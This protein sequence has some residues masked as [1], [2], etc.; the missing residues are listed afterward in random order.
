MPMP[1]RRGLVRDG[2]VYTVAL[3]L[4]RGFVFLLIPVATRILGPEEFGVVTAALVVS[5]VLSSIFTLGFNIA[6]VRL[7]FDEPPDQER[8]EWAMLI[9]AQLLLGFALAGIAWILGPFW[10]QIYQ[11]VP[12]AGPLQAAVIL[13][14][15]QASQATTLGV[16]RAARRVHAFVAV[17]VVQVVVGGVL[18]IV[19]AH[20]S[21]ATGLVAGMA[22]G[23]GLAALLGVV[24][25]YH[26]P[27]W[28]RPAFRAALL[29]AA[30]FVAHQLASWALSLSDRVLVE[31]FM[32]LDS[33]ASYQI[34]YAMAIIPMLLT[35]AVQ[36][37]WL[38]HFYA[39]DAATKRAIPGRL[40]VKATVTVAA[41]S[42]VIVLFA[43]ALF[44]ILAPADFGYPVTVVALVVSATFVR[45]SYVLVFATLSDEKDSRSIALA[46]TLG[47]LANVGLNLLLIPAWG[48]NGAAA[49]TLLAYAI[50]SWVALRRA[51]RVVGSL[52]VV[53]LTLLW[54]VGV[55]V[56]LLLSE[57]P[58]DSL[59]WIAR[60][61]IATAVVVGAI[62]TARRAWRDQFSVIA[63]AAP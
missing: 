15:A 42:G 31:R 7:Y 26:R 60:S 5:N 34:A 61:V 4:Q 25:T 41:L 35:D 32:G 1:T 27:Q 10:S 55:G 58:T 30:P 54:A 20:R 13:A 37:A 57:L 50:M 45:A 2:V 3:A 28:S 43:P 8:T 14:L 53:R 22:A 23:T 63:P 62:T 48:L 19:L 11:G 52:H 9:R 17:V 36:T 29:L 38:P 40:M 51:E 39:L 46:S 18:A 21:G 6:I 49:T 47:A 59:G 33:L 12:W 24:L 44:R 56:M 16:L